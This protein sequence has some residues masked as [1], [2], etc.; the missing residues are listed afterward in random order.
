MSP[1]VF[2]DSLEEL[3]KKYVKRKPTATGELLIKVKKSKPDLSSAELVKLL[4]D[5]MSNLGVKSKTLNGKTMW[6]MKEEK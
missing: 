3:I 1:I 6:Y 4:V 5:T 2:S